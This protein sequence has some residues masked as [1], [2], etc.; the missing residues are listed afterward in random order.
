MAIER[1]GPYRLDKIL[2][3]G[4]MGTVY[5]AGNVD[6]GQRVAVKVLAANIAREEHFRQRFET[7]IQSLIKLDHPN[8]V[9]ILAYDIEGEH[10][11]YAMELIDGKSL[12]DE[13]KNGRHFHW[14]EVAQVGIDT[15]A[16]LR[17]AH[18][19]GILHRD[20]KPGNLM[21]DA[22]GRVKLTDFGIAKLFGGRQL[23][24]DG[25][26]IG[27]VDYMSPEQAKGEP[28]SQRSDLYS[29]GSVLFSLL[30]RRPPFAGKTI[31]AALHSLSVDAPPPVREFAPETPVEMEKI[32]DRLL[33][34][35]PA[36]RIGT[37]QSVAQ[38]LQAVLDEVPQQEAA[39][40]D[41]HEFDFDDESDSNVTKSN[42]DLISE[43]PTVEPPPTINLTISPESQPTRRS[44][45]LV[46]KQAKQPN[47]QES[48][49]G[50][51]RGYT[52]VDD[53]VR[54]RE[55]NLGSLTE[56]RKTVWPFALGLVMILALVAL[57]IVYA[58]RP[59]S[60]DN[61]YQTIQAAVEDDDPD[62][63]VT[64]E[65]ECRDFLDRFSDDPRA[66]DVQQTL[67]R[68]ESIRYPRR[69]QRKRQAR[70]WAALSPAEQL[71]LQ[72]LQRGNSHPELAVGDFQALINLFADDPDELACVDAAKKQVVRLEKVVEQTREKHL[73]M[74]KE[75]LA[76]ARRIRESDSSSADKLLRGITRLYDDKPWAAEQVR[77][78]RELL[79]RPQN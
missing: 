39:S 70:G 9:R 2:G 56:S 7:E 42:A 71:F 62:K 34:K 74:L 1:L 24:A 46:D 73:Q 38:R 10:A 55:D 19:R 45:T 66:D 29:L 23:T 79:E 67:D 3:R 37:A 28:T 57:G 69:L 4:G 54:R 36:K 20:L 49:V 14:R 16:A 32:I 77:Q 51:G 63:V 21:L 5:A 59:P 47:T 65:E 40:A 35:D 15:C 11:Y 50:A 13:Q 22:E 72:A 60:A 64:V 27:T 25:G 26:V 43:Q 8:I 53:E 30:A 58:N 41:D 6:T 17:H 31:P 12:F 48:T 75:R 18:D 52:E 78:A 33:A 44:P 76:L 68:I 61:L